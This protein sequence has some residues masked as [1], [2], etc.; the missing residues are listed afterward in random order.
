MRYTPDNDFN[1]H[2]TDL[3]LARFKPNDDLELPLELIAINCS[4]EMSDGTRRN[5]S[6]ELPVS[7]I[8]V[9]DAP[10]ISVAD[11]LRI[12]EDENYAVGNIVEVVDPDFYDYQKS[13][14]RA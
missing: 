1:G 4:L 13:P 6:F 8:W 10:S 2:W 3:R 14:C 11:S 9:N 7:V 12:L 5:T